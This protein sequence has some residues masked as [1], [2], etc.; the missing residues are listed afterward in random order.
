ML[1]A[2]AAAAHTR[3]NREDVKKAV[4]TVPAY[5]NAAQKEATKNAAKIAGLEV[6]RIIS[7]PT[8]AAM[9]AGIHEQQGDQ[10]VVVFDFGGGTYDLSILDISNGTINVEATRGDMNLGGRDLDQV[11]VDHCLQ[12]FNE[13]HKHDLSEDKAAK[14]RLMQECE[15][16]KITLS[17][18]YQA[19][20]KLHTFYEDKDLEVVIRREEFE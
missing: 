3:L 9:A 6:L 5:F 10:M 8:A 4:V 7:E 12:K 16:A 18:A 15:R 11:L 17:N 14:T 19:T 1:K 13:E 20:V 2:L